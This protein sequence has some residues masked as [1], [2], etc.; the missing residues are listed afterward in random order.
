MH[1][2]ILIDSGDLIRVRPRCLY[3][4]YHYLTR[5]YPNFRTN[6]R[7]AMLGGP[8]VRKL[9]STLHR[10]DV[11]F[12]GLLSDRIVTAWGRH[13]GRFG[14]RFISIA[15]VTA[16]E[17]EHKNA[18]TK[19]LGIIGN[20]LRNLFTNQLWAMCNQLSLRLSLSLPPHFITPFQV[21]LW[22]QYERRFFARLRRGNSFTNY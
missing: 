14:T 10:W 17:K 19:S 20:Y 21:S 5:F 16:S 7:L 3:P 6:S 1:H 8:M 9:G 13:H 22:S 18:P 4:D 2:C 12:I 15:T 11:R